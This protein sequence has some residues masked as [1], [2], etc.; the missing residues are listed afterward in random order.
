MYRKAIYIF[1]L[2]SHYNVLMADSNL[3]DWSKKSFNYSSDW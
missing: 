3:G 1:S 2:L